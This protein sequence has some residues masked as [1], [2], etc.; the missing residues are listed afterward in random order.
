MIRLLKYH[1]MIHRHRTLQLSIAIM[2]LLAP[3]FWVASLII[4]ATPESILNYGMRYS[5]VWI[6]A[7]ALGYTSSFFPINILHM[8]IPVPKLYLIITSILASMPFLLI[9][10]ITITI[11]LL[12]S[13]EYSEPLV[14]S[15]RQW[16]TVVIL[17]VLTQCF[18]YFLLAVSTLIKAH[19][20]VSKKSSFFM[21]IGSSVKGLPNGFS[22]LIFST[23]IV[24]KVF[25]E[26][27]L[28][29]SNLTTWGFH[30]FVTLVLS[31]FMLFISGYVLEKY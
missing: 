16:V 9:Y 27:V 10:K 17:F 7:L 31:V 12:L 13:Q 2:I 15:S 26:L 1:F 14:L 28:I 6:S 29:E 24:F 18:F 19:L 30:S 20:K 25:R 21:L 23:S 3:I 8:L 4:N 5:F 11:L 22:S